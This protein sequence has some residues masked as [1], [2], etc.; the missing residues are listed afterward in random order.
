M[1]QLPQIN[2]RQ[3]YDQFDQSITEDDCGKHCVGHN[4][5]GKPF[6]CDICQAV[7]AVYTDEWTYLNQATRLW[8]PWLGT[9]CAGQDQRTAELRESTP[10]NMVLLACLGPD[11]CQRNY[12]A[13]SC[14]QFPFF[15]YITEDFRF[16]GLAYEWHFEPTCWLIN[17]LDLV[18]QSYRQEFV[19][20]FDY[21][22]DQWPDEMESYADLSAEMRDVFGAQGR[23]IPV[24][25]RNGSDYL[26]SPGN[27]RLRRADL[28]RV[29][30]SILYQ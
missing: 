19:A 17:H 9:E 29:S 6:C 14:R 26:L 23:R 7:P 21:V 12:R 10:E 15:P 5:S 8:R 2:F 13:L 20:A 11:Q 28:S 1:N 24:L 3:L 18:R 27:D 25:H 4:P 22:F 30:R 16:I